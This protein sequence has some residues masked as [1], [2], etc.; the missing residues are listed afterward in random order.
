MCIRDSFDPNPQAATFAFGRAEV[1]EW[2]DANG[3]AWRGQLI[4]PP[5]YKAGTRYPLVVQTHG[6][7]AHEF[8]IDGPY[9]LTTAMAARPLSAAGI[10]VLQVEDNVQAMT[11]DERE[12]AFSA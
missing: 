2:T 11:L 3:H 12:G 1:I 6:F 7:R 10:V 4:L 9:G 5:G 8:L